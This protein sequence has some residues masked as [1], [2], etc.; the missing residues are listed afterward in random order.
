MCPFDINVAKEGKPV[1]TRNGRKVRIICYDRLTGGKIA[2]II[3]LIKNGKETFE[4]ISYY[5][6]NGQQ[7]NCI[8][9][10]DLF[11]DD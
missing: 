9:E 6:P 8:S 4:N 7:A 1:I 10:L 3:A 2:P 5:L 11:I